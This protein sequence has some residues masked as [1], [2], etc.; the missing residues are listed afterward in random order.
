M[1]E[2][3]ENKIK[4]L[5]KE[6]VLAFLEED[7]DL[8]LLEDTWDRPGGGGGISNILS[9]GKYIEKG[10]VNISM[11]HGILPD[12][13]KKRLNAVSAT[14]YA[15]GISLVIHPVNPFA[16]TV[17]FNIRYFELYEK[18]VMVDAWFGGGMDMTPYY[19]FE[20]DAVHFHTT[21][22]NACDLHNESYY[23]TFKAKCD[24]Y[25]FNSHRDEHR[26]IGGIFYDYLKDQPQEKLA[27]TSKIG[28][29]FLKAYLPVFQKRKD[30]PY[31]AD[32]KIWQE[33]RRGRYV[34]FNLIHDR[35]TLFGLKTNGRTESILMSLPPTVRWEYN[36]HP[37]AGSE[38]A[39]L[40]E[41]L[42]PKDWVTLK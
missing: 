30:T 27:F 23:S 26:G 15:S 22:K 38:E 20:E 32:Q 13:M 40:L 12:E 10:G 28:D 21:L 42:K 9:N 25:F 41:A 31:N 18:D 37:E 2:Q 36:H 39:K 6:I 4:A 33:I 24:D 3:F 1:K 16:P 5:Q 35:G 11:V 17:H 14:F 19:I 7:E 8:Q 29:A 34:E